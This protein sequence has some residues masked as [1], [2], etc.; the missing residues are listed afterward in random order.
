MKFYKRVNLLPKKHKNLK[1][2]KYLSKIC[3]T[4]STHGTY[5]TIS[6]T[7]DLDLHS[8]MWVSLPHILAHV[9][10]YMLKMPIP[11]LDWS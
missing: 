10:A 11:Q 6:L 1:I 9:D 7:T 5:A 4:I 3:I 2:Q 8:S